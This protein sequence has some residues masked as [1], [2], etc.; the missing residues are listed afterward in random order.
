MTKRLTLLVPALVLSSSIGVAVGAAQ[1][2]TI[3]DSEIE[4]PAPPVDLSVLKKLSQNI[5]SQ[6]V[7]DRISQGPQG[8]PAGYAGSSLAGVGNVPLGINTFHAFNCAWFTDGTNNFEFV[9]PL[10]GGFFAIV[11]NL[12]VA[13][14]FLTGC[15]N[16]YFEQINVVNSSTGAFNEVITFPYR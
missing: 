13:Q 2:L 4:Q 9:F 12:F 10:E 16:G 1:Q 5:L 14:T 11:N 3:P 8:A 7:Q 15:V 6:S